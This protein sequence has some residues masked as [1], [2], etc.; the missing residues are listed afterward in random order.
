M[1]LFFKAILAITIIYPT[2]S[3]TSIFAVIYTCFGGCFNLILSLDTN[4]YL[5]ISQFN[6][7]SESSVNNLSVC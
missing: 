7:V 4:E 3:L 1:I 2:Q 5:L 6:Y